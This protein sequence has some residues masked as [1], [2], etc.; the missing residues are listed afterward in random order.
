MKL[1]P[2]FRGI[3]Y[4]LTLIFVLSKLKTCKKLN[5]VEIGEYTEIYI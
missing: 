5:D 2:K 4:N 1:A 3:S